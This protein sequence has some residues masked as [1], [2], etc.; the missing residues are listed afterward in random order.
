MKYYAE[1]TEAEVNCPTVLVGVTTRGEIAAV[2]EDSL[3]V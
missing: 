1:I 2:V 3:I